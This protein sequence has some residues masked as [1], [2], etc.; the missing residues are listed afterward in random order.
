MLL[1]ISCES[2]KDDPAYAGTWQCKETITSDNLVYNTTRTL[3]PTKKTF[4]EIYVIKRENSPAIS[5]IFGTNG[6]IRINQTSYIFSLKA[7]GTCVK[8]EKYHLPDNFNNSGNNG[9]SGSTG[10]RII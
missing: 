9:L 2:L 1:L 5:A 10:S 7:L 8:D 4:E 6:D 3:I